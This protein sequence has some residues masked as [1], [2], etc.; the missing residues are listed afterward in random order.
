MI[1]FKFPKELAFEEMTGDCVPAG[2]FCFSFYCDVVK[3][4]ENEVSGLGEVNQG[5]FCLILGSLLDVVGKSL[6]S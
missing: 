1:S 6:K 5:S 4:L 3:F 2:S